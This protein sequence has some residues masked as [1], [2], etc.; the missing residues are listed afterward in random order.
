MFC[1]DDLPDWVKTRTFP[2]S[3]GGILI[4][5]EALIDLRVEYAVLSFSFFIDFKRYKIYV[6]SARKLS[7]ILLIAL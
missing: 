6:F 5:N 4:R 7:S 3:E 2:F 1:S